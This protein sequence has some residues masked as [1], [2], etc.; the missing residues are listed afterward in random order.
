VARAGRG[1]FQLL[2]TSRPPASLRWGAVGWA[3]LMVFGLALVAGICESEAFRLRTIYLDGPRREVLEDVR[4]L[5]AGMGPT[6][7]FFCRVGVLAHAARLSPRV[8]EVVIRKHYPHDI[9]IWVEP[10]RPAAA[11]STPQRPDCFLLADRQGLVYEPVSLVPPGLVRLIAF[12]TLAL[13]VGQP[14]PGR[15]GQ[16]YKAVVEGSELGGLRLR[17]IDFRQRANVVAYTADATK[18]KIG[19]LDNLAR[20]LAEAGWIAATARRQGL[21]LEYIDVRLPGRPVIKP[22]TSAAPGP[23]PPRRS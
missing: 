21:R 13:Q 19:G 9:E 15:A 17:Q 3:G 8:A 7:T 23:Q 2:Q 5:L 18:I 10:R 22:C 12:P 20:K 1:Q 14:L 11:V 6:S 4:S 16:L